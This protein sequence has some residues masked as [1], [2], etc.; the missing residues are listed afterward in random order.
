[1]TLDFMEESLLKNL[2]KVLKESISGSAWRLPRNTKIAHVKSEKNL[3]FDELKSKLFERDGSHYVRRPKSKSYNLIFVIPTMKHVKGQ[4][5]SWGAFSGKY[6]GPLVEIRMKMNGACI[7]I[8]RNII[9]CLI[10]GKI[11]VTNTCF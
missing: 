9:W 6:V 1:M 2:S 3:V 8:S 7:R 11:V 10:E 5:T 4:I